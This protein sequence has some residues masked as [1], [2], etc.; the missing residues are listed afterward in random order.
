MA[1]LISGMVFFAGCNV[2]DESEHHFDNKLYINTS[3]L[4][5]DILFESGST[6]VETRELT[7][8][9]PLPVEKTVTGRF[10]YDSRLAATYNQMYGAFAEALPEDMVTIEGEQ[11]EI[12]SGSVESSAATVTFA[13]I[14]RLDRAKIY[15]AP[16]RLVDVQGI[17]VLDSKTSVYYVFKGAALVNVVAGL[18]ENRA[19]PDWKNPDPVTDMSQFTLETLV[20]CTKFGRQISTVMGI[21]GQFLIR[22]GDAGV[23][24]N[25]IQVATS[26]GNLT[27][28]DLQLETGRW[29][30]VAVTFNN[31]NVKVYIDGVEKLSGSLYMSSM[32]FGVEHSDESNG[33]PRCFWIGYSYNNDRY[34]DGYVSETRIWNRELTV[35][36]INSANHFYK[37]EPDAE[38][39]VAY[40]KFNEGAGKTIKDQTSYGNDLTV[41]SEPE[42]KAVTLPE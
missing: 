9:V 14:E 34:L 27:S 22:I 16:V 21:E 6:A 8:A 28:A 37:V 4:A 26:S 3:E 12:L 31:G 40:W 1:F 2:N 18:A 36:E 33:K 23:P 11:V 41:D 30:H 20:N 32:D 39:L 10:V 15:V 24:D 35:E 19:Y 7:V 5:P 13:G 38:G 29:Y 42:W 17:D 25:Q